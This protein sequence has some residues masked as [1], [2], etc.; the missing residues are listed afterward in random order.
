[1]AAARTCPVCG[2]PLPTD[3]LGGLCPRC[4][5]QRVFRRPPV[6]PVESPSEPPPSAVPAPLPGAKVRYFGDYELLEEIA[7]GGMGVVY[8]ARQV[9]LDRL[10]AVKMILAGPYATEE[11]IQRFRAEAQAAAR[12]QHPNIVAIHEVGVHEGQ[13]YFSMDY[14]EGRSLAALVREGPLPPARAARYVRVIAEAIHYAHQQGVLHRDLKP[15]NVL[16]DAQDQPRITDFGLAK[17]LHADSELTV[18]GQVMGSPAYLPPE[19]AGG[20]SGQ[21][22]P[23][24]DVYS[25]GAIL[26]HLLTGRPPFQGETVTDVIEQVLH[27]DPVGLR[28]LNPS[29]PRNLGTICLKCLE[30]AIGQRYESAQALADELGRFLRDEPIAARPVSRAEKGWRWCRRKPVVAGL[31]AGL[32]LALVALAVGSTVAAL[33]IA[34]ARAG[35]KRARL[36]AEE[37]ERVTRQ[38]L[39][40]MD[41]VAARTALEGRDRRRAVMLLDR[42]SPEPGQPD[43]RGWEW[44]DLWERTRSDEWCTLGQHSNVVTC[45]A[46]S[47]D[48]QWLVSG[49]YDK[50]VQVWDLPGRRQVAVLEQA[51]EVYCAAFGPSHG[52]F[53]VG[54]ADKVKL[55][56]TDR[57]Q[58]AGVLACRGYVRALGIAPDGKRL[59]CY[60][61]R[62]VVEIWNLETKT[63]DAN[64]LGEPFE[65]PLHRLRAALA[66]SRDGAVLAVG[67]PQGTIHLLNSATGSEKAVLPASTNAVTSLAFLPDGQ[68]LVASYWDTTIRLWDVASASILRV[69]TNRTGSITC[70]A[71]AADG[72]RLAT[73]SVDQI[74]RLWDLQTGRQLANF[75]GHQG[76]VEAVVFARD[77]QTVITGG[78]DDAIKIWLLQTTRSV[79]EQIPS[80]AQMVRLT[81]DGQTFAML[82]RGEKV[83]LGE[84]GTRK[85]FGSLIGQQSCVTDMHFSRDGRSLITTDL[86]GSI[87]AYDVATRRET[88]RLS[89]SPA[90]IVTLSLSADGRTWACVYT[91][92]VYERWDV[93]NGHVTAKGRLQGMFFFYMPKLVDFSPDHNRVALA[94][95]QS[96]ALVDLNT[97]RQVLRFSDQRQPIHD[98][99]YSP[100]GRF[101]A[102]AAA[103]STVSVW[104]A[105]T[106]R[107]EARLLGH[108][109]ETYTVSFSPDSRRLLSGGGDG[110]MKLWDAATWQPV[111]DLWCGAALVFAWF[112]PNENTLISRSLASGWHLWPVPSFAEIEASRASMAA[113]RLLV[114]PQPTVE[115]PASTLPSAAERGRFPRRDDRAGPNLV[116]LSRFYNLSL[117][118]DLADAL[119][120][121]YAALPQGLRRFGAVEFDVRGIVQLS[122]LEMRNRLGNMYPRSVTNI[123]VGHKLVRL[124]SLHGVSWEDPEG[125]RIG[126]YVLHYADGQ[127]VELPLVYGADLSRYWGSPNQR[128]PTKQAEVVWTGDSPGV[129]NSGG[130]MRLYQR[131]WENPR[132]DVEVE[133]IDFISAMTDSAP[134]LIAITVE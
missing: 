74:V 20:K 78:Q 71:L 87:Q 59:A 105:A 6:A 97:S 39:Y 27:S 23:Q 34:A 36:Q 11:F 124:H 9:S 33:R 42:H 15:S 88:H 63:M 44:R 73:A 79:P 113:G 95:R 120:D 51:G 45:L 130:I 53:A 76:E 89:S 81:P 18:S 22:G 66:F 48:G 58:E 92:G 25:L 94:V 5:V 84:A 40:D 127:Q 19:Q 96:L 115:K 1:M 38:N 118:E 52:L 56:Q 80:R 12:L 108:Q 85:L 107:L 99:A 28:L 106:G 7:H 57:W 26:Y 119:G 72:R 55:W 101:L 31:G 103:D 41:M 114:P 4:L 117:Q 17:Q 122:S 37:R 21:A 67:E 43:L 35:E 30:K 91:N 46:V 86:Q 69:L 65:A 32:V 102:A 50:T 126:A 61:H 90:A 98:V 64:W 62:G 100:D 29:L 68:R 77:G 3:T 16:I 133:T 14:V 123:P 70:A 8:K 10:V 134:F 24:S 82:A 125:T 104:D 93:A 75:R 109:H 132:P 54:C 116:D 128:E 83:F 112:S 13:H 131:T 110:W 49:S 111:A 129:K 47:P 121:N 60:S 2:A